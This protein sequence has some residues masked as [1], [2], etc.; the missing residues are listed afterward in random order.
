MR[1]YHDE[2]DKINPVPE[3]VWVLNEVHDIGPALQGDDEEDGHP[4]QADVVETD[5]SVEWV[6]GADGAGVVVLVPVNTP[7]TSN[8]ITVNTTSITTIHHLLNC[9]SADLTPLLI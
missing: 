4:G 3:R 1:T 5:G 6:G 7:T 9:Q 2:A 8:T